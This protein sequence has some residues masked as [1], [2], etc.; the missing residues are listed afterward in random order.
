MANGTMVLDLARPHQIYTNAA[1]T[2][3]PGVTTI[4]GTLA[5]PALLGWYAEEERK[6]IL[7]ALD[8]SGVMTAK[9]LDKFLPVRKNGKPMPY[10]EVKRDKAAD[11]GTVTHARIEAWLNHDELSPEGIPADLF[12][13]SL[14]G[15]LRFTEWWNENGFTCLTTEL[16]MVSEEMQVGGTADIVGCHVS[17]QMTDRIVFDIKTSKRSQ[18]WPYPE[19]YAQVATYANMVTETTGYPVSDVW[20]LRVGKEEG[21]EMQSVKLTMHQRDAGARLF[22]SAL[23]VYR[24]LRELEG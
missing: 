11:L 9:E 4:L 16:Q 22:R 5:K 15:L 7:S 8:V 24:A 19:T 14:N 20:V 1:G 23:G 18:Y 17:A 10:A 2:R 6:G 13:K 12:E 3:L 21:D